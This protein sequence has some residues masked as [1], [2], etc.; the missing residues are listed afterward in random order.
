MDNNKLYNML[1][2][3]ETVAVEFKRC[4]SGIGSDTYETVCSFLNRY[5]GDILLGVDDYGRVKGIPKNAA[6]DMVE[7]FISMIGNP[8]VISPT[9]YLAPEILE[10]E[11]KNIV[12]I[13]VPPSSEVHSYKKSLR[14]LV[15]VGN[16]TIILIV[17]QNIVESLFE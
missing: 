3:G 9:V 16:K 1:A 10:V 6:A 8:E 15:W 12:H 11:G 2:I 7:N 14:R 13:H 5:G 17:S 4:S